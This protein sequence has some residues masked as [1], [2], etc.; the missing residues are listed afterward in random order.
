LALRDS[1]YQVRR[2]LWLAYVVLAI[3]AILFIVGLYLVMQHSSTSL[4]RPPAPPSSSPSPHPSATGP[5][6]VNPSTGGAPP[7][8]AGPAGGSSSR[9]VPAT[10]FPAGEPPGDIEDDN[11]PRGASPPASGSSGQPLPPL[12][13]PLLV[14]PSVAPSPSI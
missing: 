13:V 2:L 1:T 7:A 12:P 8:Q 10:G 4:Y 14:V 5:G 3:G 6:P 11:P 9:S